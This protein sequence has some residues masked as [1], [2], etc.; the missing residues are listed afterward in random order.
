MRETHT[1]KNSESHKERRHTHIKRDAKTHM[2]RDTY[3]KK[4][5]KVLWRREKCC[6]YK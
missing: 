5:H 3:I 1:I 2:E 6:K 4:R